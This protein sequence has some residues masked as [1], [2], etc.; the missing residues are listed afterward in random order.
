MFV[1]FLYFFPRRRKGFDFDEESMFFSTTSIT[2]M[3]NHLPCVCE[4][5]IPVD[6]AE[7][8]PNRL[9]VFSVFYRRYSVFFGIVNTDVGIGI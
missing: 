6:S 2:I 8:I 3:Y 9:S 1:D 7:T 5:K 4:H